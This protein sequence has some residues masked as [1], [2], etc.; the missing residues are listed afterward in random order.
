MNVIKLQGTKSSPE[1]EN[2]NDTNNEYPDTIDKALMQDIACL[3]STPANVGGNRE[4]TEKHERSSQNQQ[5]K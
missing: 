3:C 1:T 5:S 4:Y 2:G